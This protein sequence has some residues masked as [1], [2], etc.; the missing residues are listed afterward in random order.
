MTPDPE[1]LN[2]YATQRDEAAFAELVRRHLDHVYSTALRLVGGDSHFAEDV[3]QMVFIDLA[4]KARSLRR[5]AALSGW[6]HTSARFA[7]A[8]AVRGE[9]RRR[10][11]EQTALT[12]PATSVT[13]APQWEQL[14]PVLDQA[15]GELSDAD[16]DAL[17][18]RYFEKKPFADI[19]AAL[20]LS[21]NAARMRVERATDRLREKLAMRGITSTVAAL[22][23]ALAQDAVGTAPAALAAQ[24]VSQA[25]AGAG[26]SSVAVL[27]TGAKL[28][29][30][31]AG[32]LV[33]AT[34]GVLVKP[35]PSPVPPASVTGLTEGDSNPATQG[36]TTA[37]VF[38]RRQTSRSN[39][40]VAAPHGPELFFVD[41]KTGR[42][43][44]NQVAWLRGWERGSRLLVEKRV[45]LDE[46]RCL[47][48]F[49][50]AYGPGY[51]ILTRVDGYADTRLRW[52]P[53][54]GEAIPESYTVRLARPATIYG[55]VVDSTD[56][57]VAGAEVA[58]GNENIPGGDASPEDHGIASLR[59]TSDAEGRWQLNRIAPD[60]LPYLV[61]GAS[62]PAFGHS[63][64]VSV[65]GRME[66]VRQLLE[67]KFVFQL[68]E[69]VTLQGVVVDL[70][71]QSVADAKVHVGGLDETGSRDAR[72][73]PDG[74]FLLPGCRP[75]TQTITAS[76]EG[77]APAAL[78][79]KLE[80]NMQ[81]VKLVLSGGRTLRIRVVD[82]NGQAIEGASVWYCPWPG[83]PG[84]FPQVSFKAK[85]SADGIVMWE[86]APEQD[87]TFQCYATGYM[88]SYEN[89]LR[90]DDQEHTISLSAALVIS[91]NVRDADSGEL[92]PRFRLGIGCPQRAAD[93]SEQPWWSS[94]DRFWPTFT[95]GTFRHSL[96]EPVVVGS[97]SR[98]YIFRFEAEGHAPYVTRVYRPDEGEVRLEV[99]LRRVEE[100]WITVYTPN[101][102]VA[103]NAHIGLVAVGSRLEL[104]PGGF[105]TRASEGSTWLR[106][107]DAKG[108]FLLPA[109]ETVEAVV[110]AHEEGYAEG[111]VDGLRKAR[112]VRLQP[113]ARIEGSWQEGGQ[114]V[115]KGELSLQ[116]PSASKRNFSLD[117]TSFKVTTDATGRFVFPQVP[118][119]LLNVFTWQSAPI[120]PRPG[121][122]QQFSL[123]SFCYQG[124][125][126]PSS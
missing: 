32:L 60:I 59:A 94:I 3:V 73:R 50:P 34:V 54:R 75:Q 85:A 5:Y 95:G 52:Q 27:T 38:E 4:R 117:A 109:D 64:H 49:D 29:L 70:T 110:L 66:M 100:T 79:V 119:G 7:A 106:K 28:A 43:I 96:E 120:Q 1:L 35:K 92:L 68:G 103:A 98:G 90:P 89:V 121:V 41:D 14:R 47:A 51:W 72:T 112:A 9:Q 40:A 87:L 77:Y 56:N 93:G 20:G 23:T 67:G 84:P 24:V 31:A 105:S 111:T 39:T 125:V 45:S 80:P 2:R 44:T 99:K 21:E 123:W 46:A 10:Q 69:G 65:S 15:I 6:L 25:L 88:R 91:G 63:E 101:G 124:G 122:R 26:A 81:P 57:P 108:Q 74:S 36:T 76:A 115:V 42:P 62:H 113:W 19:G 118:P 48:P 53:S 22:G 13:P 114:P 55:R 30:I 11:R 12:M 37:S 86:H 102:G 107:A 61:G 104:V 83:L 71:G 82:S 78:T 16:R 8:K 126:L 17:L 33:V 18:L 58:F 97:A 116:L